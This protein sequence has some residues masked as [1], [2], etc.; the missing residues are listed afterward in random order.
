MFIKH[1][2]NGVVKKTS[3]FYVIKDFK[4]NFVFN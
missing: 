3:T 1:V 4:L 2:I